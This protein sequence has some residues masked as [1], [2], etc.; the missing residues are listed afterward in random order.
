M[1]FRNMFR[2]RYYRKLVFSFVIIGILFISVFVIGFSSLFSH[3][4]I[5]KVGEASVANVKQTADSLDTVFGNCQNA[6]NSL[7]NER[8]FYSVAYGQKLDRLKEYHLINS[9]KKIITHYP[10][11][12]YMGVI[13]IAQNRYV[14][15]R[16][17]YWDCKNEMEEIRQKSGEPSRGLL[18]R[19]VREYENTEESQKVSVLTYF[20]SPYTV[21]SSGC[22]VLLDL[23][24]AALCRQMTGTIDNL[25]DQL[26]LVDQ[27]GAVVLSCFPEKEKYSVS[28]TVMSSIPPQ[29]K[30]GFFEKNLGIK[31]M[32]SFCW[33][34]STSWVV[35]GTQPWENIISTFSNMRWLFLWIA[36]LAIGIYCVLSVFFSNYIYSPI[37][38]IWENIRP[39][40]TE[41]KE[42]NEDE[43]RLISDAFYRYS[44]KEERYHWDTSSER[45]LLRGCLQGKKYSEEDWI[46]ETHPFAASLYLGIQYSVIVIAADSCSWQNEFYLDRQLYW[47]ALMQ[48][49]K[50]LMEESGIHSLGFSYT[51]EAEEFVLIC[52]MEKAKISAQLEVGLEELQVGMQREFHLSVSMGVSN[53][54]SGIDSLAEAYFAARKA[55]QERMIQGP[56]C[57]MFESRVP[58]RTDVEEYPLRIEHQIINELVAGNSGQVNAGIDR[59]FSHVSQ[60]SPEKA[61]EWFHRLYL[62]IVNKEIMILERTGKSLKEL[63][64]TAST[65]ENLTEM[66][67]F[68]KNLCH[69][70]AEQMESLPM[71]MPA[72]QVVITTKK[73]I[74]EKYGDSSMSLTTLADAAG[75][76]SPYLSQ[77]FSKNYGMSCA[78]YLAK[79]RMD[80]AAKMLRETNLTVQQISEQVGITNINYFYT[81]FKKAHGVTPRQYRMMK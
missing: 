30:S 41:E 56:L 51:T 20:Y 43:M 23:D 11:I 33:L 42:R 49:T 78:D 53:V 25:W 71:R 24:P 48:M 79:I 16:G 21:Q 57:L 36:V 37:K 69:K 67:A 28:E 73:L 45:N 60:A 47:F 6:I 64:K 44:R 77:L 46:K 32:V 5:S 40:S 55:L 8:D 81:M 15:T 80:E 61:V 39:G 35:V 58:I 7:M 22:Y 54:R 74:E 50:E 3:M 18:S 68:T 9:I 31:K 38:N 70:I 12:K 63:L 13:N 1:S 75:L 59:F 65:L 27:S 34:S 29:E 14:G 76:S 17:I 4:T 10:Y 52:Q 72:E 66:Q 62:S 19:Q 2:F 26:M